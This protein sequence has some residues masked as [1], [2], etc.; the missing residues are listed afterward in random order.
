MKYR[1]E[2]GSAY[3]ALMP[4]YPFFVSSPSAADGSLGGYAQA[5]MRA[6]MKLPRARKYSPFLR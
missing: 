3:C 5:T 1:P 6:W 2:I 4:A